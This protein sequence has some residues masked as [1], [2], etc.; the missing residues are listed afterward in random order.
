MFSVSRQ[1][2]LFLRLS[3]L[4]DDEYAVCLCALKDILD[5]QDTSSGGGYDMKTMSETEELALEG[6]EVGIKEVRA[7]MKGRFHDVELGDIDKTLHLFSG[8]LESTNH[9]SGGQFLAALRI[10]MHV[11]NGRDVQEENAFAQVF[12]PRRNFPFRVP[13]ATV[14]S[15]GAPIHRT[16]VLKPLPKNE[17]NIENS[18]RHGSSPGVKLAASSGSAQASSQTI[19]TRPQATGVVIDL[20]DSPPTADSSL[21]PNNPSRV[22]STGPE[23][24]GSNEDLREQPGS[25][26]MPI[27]KKKKPSDRESIDEENHTAKERPDKAIITKKVAPENDVI[28]HV[29][30]CAA[31]VEKSKDICFGRRGFACDECRDSKLSCKFARYDGQSAISQNTSSAHNKS[32]PSR[33]KSLFK[34]RRARNKKK[35]DMKSKIPSWFERRALGLSSP[36]PENRKAPAEVEAL[37]HFHCAVENY[38][39][40]KF[41]NTSTVREAAASKLMN[42]HAKEVVGFRLERKEKERKENEKKAKSEQLEKK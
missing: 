18:K 42:T 20:T 11:R 23:P 35:I 33:N 37:E 21:P 17:L 3:A 14:S 31:C 8:F 4:T 19:S 24:L 5:I 36:T 40:M 7:W 12:E 29:G 22:T 1:R 41:D 15:G 9:L 34:A 32:I 39:N 6:R 25:P 27:V 38:N 13:S 10:V 2:R 16:T 30:K 28:I 26:P